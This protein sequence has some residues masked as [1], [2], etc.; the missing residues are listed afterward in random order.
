MTSYLSGV[1]IIFGVL[2]NACYIVALLLIVRELRDDKKLI[3]KR[4]AFIDTVTW[5]LVVS[6]VMFLG[7]LLLA[8]DRAFASMIIVTVIVANLAIIAAIY[9]N[10]RTSKS[11]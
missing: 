7:R 8:S 10:Y 1:H 4:N 9:R 11:I 6:C 5:M 3:F 2:A